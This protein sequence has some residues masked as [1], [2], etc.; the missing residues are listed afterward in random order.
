M[1]AFVKRNLGLRKQIGYPLRLGIVEVRDQRSMVIACIVIG[2]AVTLYP[3]RVPNIP[4]CST[5]THRSLCKAAAISSVIRLLRMALRRLAR[6]ACCL[7]FLLFWFQA[8][9]DYV[10]QYSVCF[11][12]IYG[13][14]LS[15]GARLESYFRCRTRCPDNMSDRF[16]SFCRVDN[17]RV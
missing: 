13:L 5:V 16:G 3:L 10:L 1:I 12:G 9:V 11:V 17:V 7:G 8:A 14:S 15:E 2:S 6:V 4:R